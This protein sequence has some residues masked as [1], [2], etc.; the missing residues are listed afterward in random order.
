MEDTLRGESKVIFV[1]LFSSL[2]PCFNGRY[3]QSVS[4]NKKTIVV[5]VLILV[6][7]EDT[8]R[9]LLL[10][11]LVVLH[12]VLILVLMEDTLR[13]IDWADY[14]QQMGLNPCFN[15]RYSQSDIINYKI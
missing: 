4:W 9:G 1:S 2:N 3:S 6:L 8:L 12:L 15:G 11:S 14:C 5:Q 7:M 10:F 13:E